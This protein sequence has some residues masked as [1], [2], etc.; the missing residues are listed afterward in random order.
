MFSA[1]VPTKEVVARGREGVLEMH[2]SPPPR[3]MSKGFQLK[4][5]LDKEGCS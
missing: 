5:C 2:L 4:Q 1:L 3:V